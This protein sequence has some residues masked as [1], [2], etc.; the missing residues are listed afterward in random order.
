MQGTDER[1]TIKAETEEQKFSTGGVAEITESIIGQLPDKAF[2]EL[3]WKAQRG[4]LEG[5]EF[6]K[7]LALLQ[8][9]YGGE[10][11]TGNDVV[12]EPNT[13]K[14]KNSETIINSQG[15]EI[16][17]TPSENHI[18]DLEKPGIYGE[19]NSSADIFDKQGQVVTRRWYDKDGHAYRDVDMT[20]HHNPKKHPEWPH[21]HIWDWSSEKP[22]RN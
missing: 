2:E 19:V 9:Q 10:T 20:N 8:Q 5:G 7:E 18:T 4:W 16:D 12:P 3:Y 6:Q 13:S 11:L 17:I 21:E 14:N 22:K 15:R 1:G